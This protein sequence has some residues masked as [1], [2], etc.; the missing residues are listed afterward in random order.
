MSR[1]RGFISE[2]LSFVISIPL[3]SVLPRRKLASEPLNLEKSIPLKKTGPSVGS[4]RR[5]RRR[6]VVVFPL[7]LSPASPRISPFLTTNETPSTALTV[8]SSLVKLERKPF[9]RGKCFFSFSTS[10]TC[11][12]LICDPPRT[13]G[14]LRD[15]FPSRVE[16]RG[17][18]PSVFEPARSRLVQCPAHRL[19]EA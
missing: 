10:R 16:P 9:L 19:S 8:T 12:S 4:T 1:R 17:A 3:G 15:G 2:S 6:P 14:K 7:P 13:D 18:P 11:S 5:K